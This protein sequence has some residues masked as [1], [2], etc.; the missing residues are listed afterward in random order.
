MRLRSGPDGLAPDVRAAQAIEALALGWPAGS[1]EGAAYDCDHA[2]A[3]CHA[4]AFKPGLLFLFE[5]MQAHTRRL[6][7]R[8]RYWPPLQR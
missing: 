3:L 7:A 4:H 1:A 6:Q 8:R 2:L 5:R